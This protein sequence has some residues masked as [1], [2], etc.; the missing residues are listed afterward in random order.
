M[1]KVKRKPVSQ[2]VYQICPGKSKHIHVQTKQNKK[3]E[4]HKK[5]KT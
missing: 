2:G 3:K 5:N 4:N 1:M